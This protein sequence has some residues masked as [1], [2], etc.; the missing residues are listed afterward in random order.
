MNLI[1]LKNSLK[2]IEIVSLQELDLSKNAIKSV[3]NLS[4]KFYLCYESEKKKLPYHLNLI[5]ELRANENAHSRILVKL[6]QY[7]PN[8]QFA[9]L[10]RFIDFIQEKNKE[11]FEFKQ[12][13]ADCAI[14]VG[15]QYIDAFILGQTFA[16]IIENKI[17]GAKDQDK[18]IENYIN[19]AKEKKINESEIYVIY[20]TREGG[21]PSTESFSEEYKDAFKK[22]KRYIELSYRYD[23]IAW[24][25]ELD[26]PIIKENE[27]FIISALHQYLDHLRGLFNI[28][29]I[30]TNMNKELLQTIQ[31]E[32][33]LNGDYQEN[34][35]KIR[36]TL[37]NL[38]KIRVYLEDTLPINWLKFYHERM[39]KDYP[40]NRV[41]C[42]I[43]ADYPIVSVVLKYNKVEF[44][45]SIEC[46]M[47]DKQKKPY[48]GVSR[49]NGT[50]SKNSEIEK[51]LSEI[52]S[53][54]EK[55]EWWYGRK[56]TSFESAY[57]EFRLLF[58]SVVEKITLN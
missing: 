46:S 43:K 20:L 36:L 15:K 9:I 50:H 58:K 39:E 18:Q 48:F 56:Y 14:T 42:S 53:D 32:L 23:I 47:V 57:E 21:E 5:D 35:E 38:S 25:E 17:H 7:K 55:P 12:S 27:T 26:L 11:I 6:L 52:L 29:N 51:L 33:G 8:N 4:N 49:H 2:L 10:Q 31:N 34:V 44:S 37:D 41:V 22:R 19:K 24:L 30:N 3:L 28:R 13:L 45:V 16:I 54:Y 40:N 1:E